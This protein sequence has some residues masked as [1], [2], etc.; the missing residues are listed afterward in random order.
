METLGDDQ[1]QKLCQALLVATHPDLI[2]LPVNQ[3]D[4]GRDAVL[5]DERR[6]GRDLQARTFVCFQVKFSRDPSSAT[7]R[8]AIF[9][10]I[11]GEKEKVERL[12]KR[13]LAAY[14][15]L[16]NVRGTAHLGVGSI[17]RVNEELSGQFGIPSYCYWRDD[18]ERRLDSMHDIKWSFPA[19]LRGTDLLKVLLS[20]DVGE[21]AQRRN[22]AMRAYIIN[23]YRI[24]EEVKFK[25]VELQNKLL[26]IFVD[27]PVRMLDLQG[28][29]LLKRDRD[30]AVDDP[31]E[32]G[33][34]VSLRHETVAY[35]IQTVSAAAVFLQ[36]QHV[37]VLA[38]VVLEGAPGQGKSTITQYICQVHRMRFLSKDHDLSCVLEGHRNSLIRIPLR[39]DLRDYAICVQGRTPFGSALNS[40]LPVGTSI[41]L[42]AFLVAQIVDASGGFI[43]DVNDLSRV[44]RES[45]TLIVLDGFDEVA[46]IP[47]RNRLIEQINLA[48]RRLEDQAR[49]LQIIVTSRPSAFANSPGFS[50]RDWLHLELQSLNREQIYLYADKWMSA[51]GLLDRQKRD[52]RS[53]MDNRLGQGHV[54]HLARNPMQLAILLSLINTKG[55]SLPDKRTAL[56]ESYIEL[57]FDREA[58]KSEV[59]RDRRDLL[60]ILHRYLAWVLQTEAEAGRGSGSGSMEESRMKSL[61]KTFMEDQGHDESLI[62]SLFTGMV[63]RVVALVSRVQ[64]TYEFE[65]QPLREYFCARFLYETAPY[66]P[67][68]SER[69]GTK[70]DLFKAIAGNFY[71]LNVTRFYAGCYSSGELAS[72]VDGIEELG[73]LSDL[74]K[75]SHPRGL[76]LTLLSDWVFL[77]QPHAARRVGMFILSEPG[78]KQYLSSATNMRSPRPLS[79]P[80]GSG[81][82]ALVEGVIQ[83]LQK[84]RETD[85]QMALTWFL[86]ANT[87]TEQAYEYWCQL[88]NACPS[89]DN[90]ISM[91]SP[92]Q[93]GRHISIERW[94]DICARYGSTALQQLLDSARVDVLYHDKGLSV[95]PRTS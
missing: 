79:A 1:F 4:G 10:L 54:Q 14:Y 22:A 85:Y 38:R 65:V 47:T 67:P 46:D 80:E 51:R 94:K 28:A 90:W 25:Q 68:G 56:Y 82:R 62:D 50:E 15:L 71:W 75:T 7:E 63:E 37:G 61:L 40:E 84:A 55:L 9:D 8:D 45:H 88:E 11:K 81:R 29:S 5:F 76:A 21:A 43:F 19:I 95:R 83:L 73:E 27:V 89:G 6:Y 92:L 12:K 44:M 31:I 48:S 74:G 26:D 70:P 41:G 36:P 16:T 42:E 77:Q 18:I 49:S 87:S 66:S 35:H 24:D 60:I 57:F 93:I 91:I 64:G 30:T 20:G 34:I 72:L 13:G 69:K 59:V 3:P 33:L 58:E 53:V 17:D 23:Q 32:Q 78:L 86:G 39:A 2:C 52:F